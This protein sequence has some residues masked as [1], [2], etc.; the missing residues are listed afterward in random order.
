M[1]GRTPICSADQGEL[2]CVGANFGELPFLLGNE[3]G[4]AHPVAGNPGQSEVCW[5]NGAL[6]DGFA[7]EQ[8]PRI[9][10]WRIFLHGR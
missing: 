1:D 4:A 2:Q 3:A 7:P 9:D 10:R 6:G 5:L 8:K